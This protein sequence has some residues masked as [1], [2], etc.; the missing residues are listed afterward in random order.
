MSSNR[1]KKVA[2]VGA[3]GHVGSHIVSELLKNGRHEITALTRQGSNSKCPEGVKVAPVDYSKE[4]T[5]VEALRGHDFLI[6]SLSTSA[7]PDVH[8]TICSAAGKAGIQ[9]IMPNAYG[10]DPKNDRLLNDNVYGKVVREAMSD[11]K[12]AGANYVILTCGFWYE[13]SLVAGT[14]FFGFDVKDKKAVLFDDGT[15]KIST[16]TLA[17]CGRAVAALLDLPVT[18]EGGKP[19]LE[20]WKDNGLYVASF[21]V[22][23]RDMLDSIHRAMGDSDSDWTIMYEP[24]EERTNKALDEL[25]KGSFAG[26]AQAMYTRYFYKNGDGDF[27]TMHGLANEKL[28]LPKEDLDAIT[29][30][31][32]DKKLKDGFVYAN[33]YAKKHLKT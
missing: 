2:I 15:Q 20:D 32:V 18:K 13:W 1:I 5:I 22:S 27:E 23:Q 10:M 9:W 11:V 28:G 29:K 21:H 17:Q 8:P 4:E 19:A 12:S 14:D 25:K 33:E 6:I 16:S 26:F 7:P 31:T 3:T 30:W 24:S